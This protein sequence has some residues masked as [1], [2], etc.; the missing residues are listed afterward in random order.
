VEWERYSAERPTLDSRC[1]HATTSTHQ[2]GS[3]SSLPRWLA[4]VLGRARFRRTTQGCYPAAAAAAITDYAVVDYFQ[5]VFSPL[6]V[7]MIAYLN[8]H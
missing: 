6:Y 5:R 2:Q 4:W 1:S 3:L 8:K 7:L